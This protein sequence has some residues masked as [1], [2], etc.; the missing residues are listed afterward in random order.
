MNQTFSQDI[1]IPTRQ[2]IDIPTRQD[3][4]IPTR[5]FKHTADIIVTFFFPIF[6]HAV[7]I[8]IF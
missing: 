3:I 8:A 4:D 7:V 6:H 5:I 1:D 2:D